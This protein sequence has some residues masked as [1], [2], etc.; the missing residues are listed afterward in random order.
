VSAGVERVALITGVAGQDGVY[1]AKLLLAKGY[2]VTGTVFPRSAVP[3]RLDCYLGGVDL[4][5]VDLRD[6]AAMYGVLVASRPAEVYNL[7]ALSSVGASW[8]DAAQVADVNGAAVARL[9]DAL[10]R[11][12]D[13]SGEAPRFFQA[14]SSEIFGD[15]PQQPQNEQ[16]PHDPRSPYAVAKHLAH[17]ATVQARDLHGVFACNGILF[18]HESPLRAP[19]FVT[20]KITRAVAEIAAGSRDEVSLGNLDVRRD[21]GAAADYVH[22]MW[23]MLQQPAA[24]DFVIATRAVTSLREFIET[25]FRCIGV[26]DPW[27]YVR[28]D[29]ELMRPADVPQSWGDPARAKDELGWVASTTVTELIGQMVAVDIERLRSGVEESPEFLSWPT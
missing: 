17:D 15:A 22:A 18:N 13:E 7:A 29:P 16:T 4:I 14:S 9:L 2:R 10:R 5:E 26:N 21:W 8:A 3:G 11:Y 19:S 6:D 23:L 1:L 24:A 25:A 27:P 12:R 20:R 28:A